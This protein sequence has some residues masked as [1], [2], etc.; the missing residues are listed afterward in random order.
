MGLS[1]VMVL[2]QFFRGAGKCLRNDVKCDK[3]VML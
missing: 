3:R 2:N 1:F